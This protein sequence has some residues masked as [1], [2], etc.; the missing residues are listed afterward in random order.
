MYKAKVNQTEY[1]IELIGKDKA[2]VNGEEMNIDIIDVNANTFHVIQN[3]V[4]YNAEV[5]SFDPEEKTY[6]IKVNGQIY[7]VALKD[8]FDI[9]L[10]SMGMDALASK[11][12]NDLKA[13][14]PG[15]V[16]DI[17]VKVGDV[18]KKGDA[19]VVLEAMKMENILKASSDVVVKKISVEKG[20]AVEKNQLLVLFES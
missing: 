11:K 20:Q 6:K 2:T 9:L 14:M 7:Q 12:A 8:K 17:R 16:L 10:Q 15:L 4:S 19:L 13:P 3:H 18:V 1:D 5:V